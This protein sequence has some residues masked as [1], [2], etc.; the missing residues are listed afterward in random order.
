MRRWLKVLLGVLAALVVLLILNAIVIDHQ[1]KGA[2]VTINGARIL[3]LSGGDLQ[4]LDANNPPHLTANPKAP[5]PEPIV[6]LHCYTCS[7]DWWL[8]LAPI[9]SEGGHRVIA[10]DLLGHGGSEMPSNGYSMQDQAQLVAQALDRLQVKGPVTVVGH[11]LGGAVATA[12]AEQSPKLVGRLVIIDSEPDNSYGHLDFV[13]RLPYVPVIG[14]AT[15]RLK[16]SS[17]V[18]EGLKEAFAPGY[19]VPDQFVDDVKR[20]TYTAYDA[21]HSDFD[22][23]VGESPLDKRI[24]SLGVPLLAIFGAED[25]IIDPRKALSAYAGVSGAQTALVQGAGHSPNVERPAE[26]AALILRFSRE[27]ARSPA[28]KPKQAP[29]AAPRRVVARCEQAI[30]GPG[31]PDWRKQSTVSGSFGLFGSGRNLSRADRIGTAFVTKVP[32]VLE[33]HK[34][35]VLRVPASE[36][37]RVSLIY[38]PIHLVRAV[39]QGADQVTFRPCP[40][41]P[42]TVWPGGLALADR[43]RIKLDVIADGS[44][45]R[46]EVG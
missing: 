31:A 43:H 19:D 17:L 23:Y 16:T 8:K 6:L 40:S 10:I 33:G 1:T 20:M 18:R 46:L 35:V 12:L 34:K 38:G 2:K 4:V 45:K 41:K 32:A 15:W 22:S 39:N 11:S 5:E 42:R 36:R 21:S 27:A 44:V 3:H 29:K 13:A 24:S 25:Q 26:T 28:A 7:I 30:I 9:L 37:G 14:E